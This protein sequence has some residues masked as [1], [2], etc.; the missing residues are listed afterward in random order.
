MRKSYKPVYC[1]NDVLSLV[2]E[3]QHKRSIADRAQGL[4]KEKY[5]RWA[6]KL[7]NILEG[8]MRATDRLGIEM[9]N[10]RAILIKANKAKSNDNMELFSDLIYMTI[11]MA[12]KA[13]LLEQILI[14]CSEERVSFFLKENPENILVLKTEELMKIKIREI[15]KKSSKF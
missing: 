13:K 12:R 10:I 5:E 4:K 14:G 2:R 15:D 3:I 11:E 8:K 6:D 7:S 1:S 9:T